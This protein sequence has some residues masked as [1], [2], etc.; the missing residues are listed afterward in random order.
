MITREL[1]A[2]MPDAEASVWTGLA[3]EEVPGS[4]AGLLLPDGTVVVWKP[5]GHV[6][7]VLYADYAEYAR[8]NAIEQRRV[9]SVLGYWRNL[10]PVDGEACRKLERIV[11][12][13]WSCLDPDF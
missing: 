1:A 13:A 9:G 5:Q 11:A 4:W 6:T 3:W 2:I 8:E 10:L 7:P 12:T